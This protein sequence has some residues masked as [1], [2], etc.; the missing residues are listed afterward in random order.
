MSEDT[1][2]N[3]EILYRRIRDDMDL[4]ETQADGT[5]L[6]NS[7]AFAERSGRPSVDR[8]HLCKNGPKHTLGEFSGGVTSLVAG[9][10][11]SMP[12]LVQYDKD[13]S[14]VQTFSID[15]EPMP[16]IDEPNE[17]DNP[18]HAEIYTNPPCTNRRVL[19]RFYEQL[20]LLA[21]A[22]Q[23]ALKPSVLKERRT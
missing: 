6:F 5:V 12:E 8:A 7:M 11:R 18:A 4:Y 22:R 20:A 9:D 21:N 14:R 2:A 16:I 1:I 13:Q 3:D 17:P 23:W 19:K 15:V 10:V